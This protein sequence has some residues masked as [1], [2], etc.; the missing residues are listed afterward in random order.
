VRAARLLPARYR[1]VLA[2]GDGHGSE[3][4]HD[5]I[6]QERL[7]ERVLTPGYVS[8]AQL[9]SL[10]RAASVFLFPSFEEG[11][12][13]PVLDA[14][15]RG[16]PVVAAHT[17]SLPEVAGEAARYVDPH[18]EAAIAAE[19]QRVAEDAMVRAELVALGLKRAAQFTWHH[20]ARQTLAVYD[21]VL[22][23]G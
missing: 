10:Y 8:K 15:A 16:V 5:Y 1:F 22:R 6:R 3:A 19:V 12:G 23:L 4:V 11:F 18:F 17:S 9:E 14:M 2:G 21:E 20:T 7:A 13:I